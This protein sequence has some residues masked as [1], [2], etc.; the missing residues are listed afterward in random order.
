D[1]TQ[2]EHTFV[3]T[4]VP[5][6]P[7]P[8]LLR[9]FSAPVKLS[10]PYSR[11][12]L[13]TLMRRDSDGF[14]RWDAGQ[15]LAVAALND[16]MAAYRGGTPLQLEPRLITALGELLDDDSLDPAMV[17]LM[18]TLPSEAYLAELATEIDVEAIHH[19]RWFARTQIATQLHDKLWRR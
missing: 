3:F 16:L 18:L 2:A 6:A 11:D 15:Q 4:D 17:A 13:L 19:V 1:I 8:S 9:G 10:Y 14:C 12:Q 7:V 5:E